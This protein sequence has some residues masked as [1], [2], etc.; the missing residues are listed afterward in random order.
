MLCEN[1]AAKEEQLIE[2]AIIPD[3]IIQH[4]HISGWLLS[5]FE[6]FHQH[7]CVHMNTHAHVFLSPWSLL[8]NFVF[9]ALATSGA[10]SN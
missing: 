9:H 2:T 4:H 10:P 7:M 3:F 5:A 1:R 8:P 6:S